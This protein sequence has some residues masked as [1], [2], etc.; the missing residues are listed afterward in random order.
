MTYAPNKPDAPNPARASR[1]HVEHFG[2]PVGD[3]E[4]SMKRHTLTLLAV[5]AGVAFGFQHHAEETGV[6]TTN[7]VPK[8]S[9]E[10]RVV[11]EKACWNQTRRQSANYLFSMKAKLRG[12]L[13]VPLEFRLY[14]G[15]DVDDQGRD[16]ITRLNAYFNTVSTNIWH[17]DGQPMTIQNSNT[18]NL[19]IF[20]SVWLFQE[21]RG[22][23]VAVDTAVRSREWGSKKII[24][25][26]GAA[27]RSQPIRSETNSTP[28]A[29]GS[30]R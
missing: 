13:P 26:F 27:N 12:D 17:P 11:L 19:R 15:S 29:A 2:R 18:V 24:E 28:S 6:N 9:V 23:T 1:F 21:E 30:H 22:R 3:P 10:L 20:G 16:S 5:A 7:K 4:R 8:A 25:Q 14:Q